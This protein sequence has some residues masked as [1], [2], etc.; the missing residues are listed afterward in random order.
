[1]NLYEFTSFITNSNV[2]L[3]NYNPQIKSESGKYSKIIEEYVKNRLITHKVKTP[4]I[5]INNNFYNDYYIS[6]SLDFLENINLDTKNTIKKELIT[7]LEIS[8]EHHAKF[9]N[10]NYNH[11]SKHDFNTISIINHGVTFHQNFIEPLI[12]KILYINSK[13][14]PAILHRIPWAP[15]FYPETLLNKIINKDHFQIDKSEFEY[16]TLYNFSKF[17][18]DLYKDILTKN[19]IDIIQDKIINISTKENLITISNKK[20]YEYDELIIGCDITEYYS[21]S[22]INDEIPLFE[23][24][25]YVFIFARFPYS[26]IIKQFS[27]LFILDLEIPIYRITNQSNLEGISADYC[28]FI[29]EINADYLK[30]NFNERIDLL[31]KNTLIN[32]KIIR[33]YN[34]LF[35]EIKEFNNAI[36]L[37]TFNN[38]ELYNKIKKSIKTK[39]NINFIGNIN[40]LFSNSFND[41]IIQALLITKKLNS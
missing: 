14:I 38:L 5:Y 8:S 30:N 22:N 13:I 9:K 41:N 15:L 31:I 12:T 10:N 39:S 37:P 21:L 23:K 4:E 17:S 33:E 27:V 7:C 32:L 6:N 29:F 18:D 20:S 28:D 36:N 25:N 40:A 2:N 16:P 11:F 24:T 3:F 34:P 1:M 35:I 26:Q 19:N